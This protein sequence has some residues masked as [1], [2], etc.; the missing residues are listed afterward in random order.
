MRNCINWRF[1]WI[2]ILVVLIACLCSGI[3]RVDGKTVSVI[4]VLVFQYE[5]VFARI[6]WLDAFSV[7]L[8]GNL[9]LVLPLVTAIA[10]M[11]LL[12]DEL[13]TKN[14]LYHLSR[15]GFQCYVKQ[16]YRISLLCGFGILAIAFVIFGTILFFSFP[17]VHDFGNAQVIGFVELTPSEMVR[18][19]LHYAVYMSFW[20]GMLV[21]FSCNVVSITQNIYVVL[22]LPFLFNYVFSSYFMNTN[23]IVFVGI[24]VLL[25]YMGYHV[26]IWKY[27][28]VRA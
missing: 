22:C 5:E 4:E 24:T 19:L 27:Q 20:G 25:Y 26:W 28:G 11:P 13:R 14:Y 18:E 2:S 10:T 7:V 3:D 8:Y 17:S 15:I 1:F 9:Y 12:C 6:T 23:V 21:V 16:R